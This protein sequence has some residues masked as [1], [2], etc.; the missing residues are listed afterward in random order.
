[1]GT[2][3]AGRLRCAQ[4]AVLLC[5]TPARP[6]FRR[7]CPA[8]QC[9]VAAA[10]DGPPA[11]TGSTDALPFWRDVAPGRRNRARRFPT[12]E[13]MRG[14][15]SPKERTLITS[16]FDA[17]GVLRPLFS[18]GRHP[19]HAFEEFLS[20]AG[21]RIKGWQLLGFL[22]ACHARIE[23]LW[24]LHGARITDLSSEVIATR[25]LYAHAQQQQFAGGFLH[26]ECKRSMLVYL[27]KTRQP[28]AADEIKADIHSANQRLD[29][30]C[31]TF[32]ISAHS[33]DRAPPGTCGGVPR[34]VE[35]YD[36]LRGGITDN[37][38]LCD[39]DVTERLRELYAAMLRVAALDSNERMAAA[40]FARA[41]AAAE[42][43]RKA[44]A[45]GKLSGMRALAVAWPPQW[46]PRG[47][48][49]L[50]AELLPLSEPEY[51]GEDNICAALG[52]PAHP[53]PD[54][55]C[56]THLIR[57]AERPAGA[58][59]AAVAAR[60]AG[61]LDE[62][63]VAA[64]VA[65]EVEQ[66]TL[67]QARRAHALCRELRSDPE[68]HFKAWAELLR[69]EQQLGDFDSFVAALDRAAKAGVYFSGEPALFACRGLCAVAWD[70][71]NK[72]KALPAG[73]R[74][75][76]P[77]LEG[78]LRA[79]SSLELPRRAQEY[80]ASA[81][82]ALE[83]ASTGSAPRAGARAAAAAP[84]GPAE[85][86]DGHGRAGSD[87]GWE[88]RASLAAVIDAAEP[89]D[90]A[91]PGTA[92]PG[93]SA[94]RAKSSDAPDSPRAKAQGEA[95]W[96]AAEAQLRAGPR[97]GTVAFCYRPPSGGRDEPFYIQAG[98][99]H[100]LDAV[101]KHIDR[102]GAS[103]E[104]RQ[105]HEQRLWRGAGDRGV[106]VLLRCCAL[107][108]EHVPRAAALGGFAGLLRGE[109]E[110]AQGL[111]RRSGQAG[112]AGRLAW[113][114]LRLFE[115]AVDELL[116]A[117]GTPVGDPQRSGLI[118][119]ITG[120][121]VSAARQK[122]QQPP[123]DKPPERLPRRAAAGAEEGQTTR[124][125]AEMLVRRLPVSGLEGAIPHAAPRG[126]SADRAARERPGTVADR[127]VSPPAAFAPL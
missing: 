65:Q 16:Y 80:L 4:P 47:E 31:Y 50:G 49:R 90:P 26:P 83:E 116:D 86:G 28:R 41:R 76:A 88:H 39:A 102:G 124:Q 125:A 67:E 1:M 107:R 108:L 113:R 74:D 32:L 117:R 17:S 36:E 121:T 93:T 8:R 52:D 120:R 109:V 68:I 98:G 19:L 18:D 99:V 15:C 40:F 48:L 53:W 97:A 51:R 79:G 115:D 111:F 81:K 44:A 24:G 42:L 77:W 21:D 71:R 5:G 38:V 82:V 20:L 123:P 103:E 7:R 58:W 112:V 122:P 46:L 105:E 104:Q 12:G 94:A 9:S 89:P 27:C 84:V 95:E 35:L 22:R 75:W 63:G 126:G 62:Q 43:G 37:T 119:R 45:Q 33:A 64:L 101:D 78:Y 73:A 106:A 118:R 114:A 57:A 13:P 92:G 2:A 100:P 61:K 91:D 30:R 127:A 60:K 11:G 10:G 87:I 110:K 23:G 3:P 25:K 14:Q 54:E 85:S 69:A 59:V 6:R 29:L 56:F 66:G 55:V 70:A 34:C 96:A 72:G